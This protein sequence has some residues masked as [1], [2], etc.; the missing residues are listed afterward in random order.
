MAL[1]PAG[2]LL[3]RGPVDV[4]K[5]SLRGGVEVEPGPLSWAEMAGGTRY[6][7]RGRWSIKKQ[8]T[9]PS[10]CPKKRMLCR[11][12]LLDDFA[13][14]PENLAVVVEFS[15]RSSRPSRAGFVRKFCVS[16]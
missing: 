9:P 15:N 13:A 6:V 5:V 16:I 2:L 8:F 12:L 1:E 14:G 3:E 11:Y 4:W 7:R 10:N